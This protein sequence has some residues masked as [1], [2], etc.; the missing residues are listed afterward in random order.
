MKSSEFKRSAP[1]EIYN[2]MEGGLFRHYS[3]RPVR[4]TLYKG[5]FYNK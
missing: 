1:L 3:S 2:T 4:F 5:G